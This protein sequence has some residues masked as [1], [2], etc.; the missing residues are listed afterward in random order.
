LIETATLPGVVPLAGVAD[1]QVAEVAVV[2]F[3]ALPL[4]AIATVCEA[5]VLL[6]I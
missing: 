4:L 1:S 5:G 2:K 3:T 6:P